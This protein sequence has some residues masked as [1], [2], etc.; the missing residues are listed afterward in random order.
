M[1]NLFEA[2]KSLHYKD[3]IHVK[4]GYKLSEA[5]IADN[6]N[7]LIEEAVEVQAELLKGLREGLTWYS[8]QH[9]L[10]KDLRQELADLAIVYNHL[11]VRLNL[12]PKDVEVEALAKLKDAFTKDPSKVTASKAGVT[13]SGRDDGPVSRADRAES[14]GY[15]AEDL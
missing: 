11:L 9:P 4:R 2:V 6:A 10:S 12:T 7:H 5:S 8:L 13:R 15:R 1:Q 3:A 14:F